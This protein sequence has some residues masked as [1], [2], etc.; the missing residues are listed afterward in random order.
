MFYFFLSL[1]LLV[2]T[3]QQGTYPVNKSLLV[4]WLAIYSN[5]SPSFHN[6]RQSACKKILQHFNSI[7]EAFEYVKKQSHITS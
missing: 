6:A 1:N 5:K 3:N 4:S 7:D 2:K